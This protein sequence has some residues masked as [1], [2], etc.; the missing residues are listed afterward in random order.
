MFR[1]DEAGEG[2]YFRAFKDGDL[3]ALIL[4]VTAKKNGEVVAT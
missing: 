2:T 1:F 4:F 3:Y